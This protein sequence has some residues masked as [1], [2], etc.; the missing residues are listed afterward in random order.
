MGEE[1]K[2]GEVQWETLV[3]RELLRAFGRCLEW[4]PL[5]AL[6]SKR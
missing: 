1:G 3:L 2:G 4:G 5:S 6:S